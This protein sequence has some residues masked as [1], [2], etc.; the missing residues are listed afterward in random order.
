MTELKEAEKLYQ[1]KMTEKDRTL[2]DREAIALGLAALAR[3]EGA[4]DVVVVVG[5]TIPADDALE[6]K[7]LGVA[8]VFTGAGKTILAMGCMADAQSEENFKK[9]LEADGM[10]M[11]GRLKT[12]DIV[13]YLSTGGAAQADDSSN[14]SAI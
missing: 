11:A 13:F 1:A 4:G 14:F 7:E 8:E 2:W 9:Q 10:T 5:G 12:F 3:A 6:L